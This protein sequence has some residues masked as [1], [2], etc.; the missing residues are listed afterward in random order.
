MRSKLKNSPAFRASVGLI[1]TVSIL[2]L[3]SPV[4]IPQEA[5][6]IST[7]FKKIT[8]PIHLPK[9]STQVRN[10]RQERSAN[11]TVNMLGHRSNNICFGQ[12]VSQISKASENP[13]IFFLD[14]TCN[15]DLLPHQACAI[16][17]ACLYNPG[18]RVTLK[19]LVD[20]LDKEDRYLEML[21]KL[22]YFAL[23][24]LHP[25][26]RVAG[27]PL[28]TWF[29]SG[30]WDEKEFN[31]KRPYIHF[32]LSDA[33]RYL[34]LYVHGGIYLDTDVVSLRTV[35]NLQYINFIV[36]Q[37]ATL[38]N[39]A[40]MGMRSPRSAFIRRAL[41]AYGKENCKGNLYEWEGMVLSNNTARISRIFKR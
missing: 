19:K 2:G 36:K 12:D 24:I 33:F 3:L 34:E 27:T 23:E 6:T 22:P 5:H 37:N 29:R 8:E 16:E 32:D 9:N 28:E 21:N 10:P 15:S 1:F 31:T 38:V 35:E 30:V 41:E 40:A 26:T 18:L 4:T 13:D 20:T 17:S 7:D 11:N 14:T 25:W 39:S